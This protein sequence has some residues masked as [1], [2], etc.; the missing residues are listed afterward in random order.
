MAGAPPALDKLK[1]EADLNDEHKPVP[2]GGTEKIADAPASETGLDKEVMEKLISTDE[3]IGKALTEKANPMNKF[4]AMD[5]LKTE[6]QASDVLSEYA[7]ADISAGPDPYSLPGASSD[8]S[9]G[10][11]PEA[12]IGTEYG[13]KGLNEMETSAL[14]NGGQ[15]T[16]IPEQDDRNMPGIPD[17]YDHDQAGF[18]P[19]NE[20]EPSRGYEQNDELT[21]NT[22]SR[23]KDDS[24]LNA[25]LGE[26]GG[27]STDAGAFS[28]R[29]NIPDSLWS[30]SR[31]LDNSDT[32]SFSN[33]YNAQMFKKH[34]ILRPKRDGYVSPF[35]GK[36]SFEIDI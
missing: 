12:A 30:T 17:G 34:V 29:Q 24:Y 1:E 32:N 9:L 23:T 36:E 5:I 10:A 2:E 3:G 21:G 13:P 33:N 8:R 31:T 20:N 25:A 4:S 19:S 16:S 6:K 18:E 28:T 15:M 11:L 26:I 7:G 14:L 22:R 35:V 27:V